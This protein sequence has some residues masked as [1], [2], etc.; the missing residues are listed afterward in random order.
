MISRRS[1]GIVWFDTNTVLHNDAQAASSKSGK[2]VVLARLVARA[3]LPEMHRK[4]GNG[5]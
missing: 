5:G 2:R 1:S 3:A 4:F